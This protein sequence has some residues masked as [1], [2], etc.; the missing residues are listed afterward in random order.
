MYSRAMPMYGDEEEA[1]ADRP[2][3]DDSKDANEH[4]ELFND[5]DDE[6]VIKA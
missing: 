5:F 4:P 6:Q 1:K 3:Y 2:I